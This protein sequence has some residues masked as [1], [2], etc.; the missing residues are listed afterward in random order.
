MLNINTINEAIDIAARKKTRRRDVRK[1]LANKAHYAYE[2]QKLLKTHG[3]VNP[4]YEM[5]EITEGSKH[6]TRKI[7]KPKFIYDQLIQN[8]LI[9]QLKPI[10][11][12]SLYEH[13]HGSLE[14]RGPQQSMKVIAKWIKKD[15]KG[16]RYCLQMDIH[17]CYQTI[18][19]NILSGMYHD[20]IHDNDFNIE[21]DRVI[22]S[23]PSG[24]AIGAPTSIWHLHFMLTPY[25]HFVAGLDG[26]SH[27]LRHADDM[28]IFGPN[29]KKLHKVEQQCMQYLK[30][31]LNLEVNYVHQVFPIEWTD[32]IGRKHGRPLDVCG[33]L[34]Y[35]D[36]TILRESR[37]LVIT[38]KTSK[39]GKKEKPTSF[40][41]MQAISQIGWLRHARTYD[42][43]EE[44]IKPFVSKRKMRKIVSKD[45]FKRKIKEEEQNEIHT[46]RRLTG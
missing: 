18:D 12:G 6:K 45:A 24:I 2:I 9:T 46:S 15:P 23:L 26:V 8:V 13:A 17:H 42:M 29:K 4:Q 25:D 10:V 37:M 16:T 21:N 20:K 31:N 28:V 33:Y 41:A 5:S 38:R 35:R 27:Y 1:V 19:Q 14:D 36:R 32:K 34:F 40:D 43:Y 22:F 39:V 30:E 44:R 11:M 7:E 3:Y